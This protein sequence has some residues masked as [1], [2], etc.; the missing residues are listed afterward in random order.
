MPIRQ[1][2]TKVSPIA[3]ALR[4]EAKRQDLTPYALAKATGLS[5]TTVDRGLSGEVSPTLATVE[6]VAEALG[7]RLTLEKYK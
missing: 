7:F 4:A 5:I 6:A 3:K 2:P 1:A